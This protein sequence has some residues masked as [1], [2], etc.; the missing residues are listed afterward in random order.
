MSCRPLRGHLVGNRSEQ[1]EPH[2]ETA[3]G[4]VER[5]ATTANLAKL[6]KHY[7]ED[8]P[9]DTALHSALELNHKL[10]FVS[11]W[12][13]DKESIQVTTS[14]PSGDVQAEERELLERWFDYVMHLSAK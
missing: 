1:Q 2:I 3:T 9:A 13:Y 8:R 10:P 5:L 7:F 4:G 12:P 6:E 11:F 14:Y